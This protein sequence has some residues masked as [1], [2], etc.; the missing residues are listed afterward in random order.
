M[1]RPLGNVLGG[2]GLI[3]AGAAGLFDRLLDGNRMPPVIVGVG[4]VGW[5]LYQAVR[6]SGRR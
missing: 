1:I 4:L 3:V 6:G 5:G 2:I